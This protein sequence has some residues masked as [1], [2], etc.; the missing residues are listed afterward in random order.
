M[1]VQGEEGFHFVCVKQF[2]RQAF[3][4]DIRFPSRRG[5][6]LEFGEGET[7]ASSNPE[8]ASLMPS[9]PNASVPYGNFADPVM[10]F[11]SPTFSDSSLL[12][13]FVE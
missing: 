6:A 13:D 1:R 11:N 3:V 2:R 8:M 10:L 9:V 12:N 7:Y 5:S 4:F